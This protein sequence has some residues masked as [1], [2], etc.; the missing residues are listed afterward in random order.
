[1]FNFKR[2][3]LAVVQKVTLCIQ[4]VLKVLSPF[5]SFIINAFCKFLT[6]YE[7]KTITMQKF[8]LFSI[9]VSQCMGDY[10]P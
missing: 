7:P 8:L 4:W 5:L 3:N 2:F 10:F 6:I 9:S 1:M